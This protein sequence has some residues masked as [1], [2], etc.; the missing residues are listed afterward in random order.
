MRYALDGLRTPVGVAAWTPSGQTK[1]E[2]VEHAPAALD[3]P[4][5]EIRDGF[6]RIVRAHADKIAAVEEE[7][8]ER[9]GGESGAGLAG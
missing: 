8:A 3:L 6:A 2:L 7:T 5:D 9:A 4:D 1:V